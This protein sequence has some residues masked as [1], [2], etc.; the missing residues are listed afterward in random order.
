MSC[1]LKA[2]TLYLDGA[3]LVTKV[4][5]NGTEKLRSDIQAPTLNL[6]YNRIAALSGWSLAAI[7]PKKMY[8]YRQPL[9]A[10]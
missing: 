1:K 4:P 9:L 5:L 2:S 6:H 8:F 10:P 3:L 7:R